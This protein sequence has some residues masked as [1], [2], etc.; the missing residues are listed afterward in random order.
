MSMFGFLVGR[1][2]FC[3]LIWVS[4]GTIGQLS[5]DDDMFGVGAVLGAVA[6]FY[7]IAVLIGRALS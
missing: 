5:K 6:A 4:V 1:G 3:L 7:L 2:V